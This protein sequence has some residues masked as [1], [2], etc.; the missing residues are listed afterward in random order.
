MGCDELDAVPCS[1]REFEIHAVII[2]L[3]LLQN[4]LHLTVTQAATSVL[5]SSRAVKHFPAPHRT[6]AS[7]ADTHGQVPPEP[8]EFTVPVI[9]PEGCGSTHCSSF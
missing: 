4:P 1:K 6:T 3:G 9:V 7:R 5:P 8:F 2:F